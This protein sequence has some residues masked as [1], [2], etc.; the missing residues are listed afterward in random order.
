MPAFF[1]AMN[2]MKSPMPAEMPSLKL[3]GMALISHSR[4]GTTLRI[5]NTTPDRNTAPSATCHVWPMPSTTVY[6]KKAF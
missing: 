3:R 6:A 1:M 2:A 5:R 4:T